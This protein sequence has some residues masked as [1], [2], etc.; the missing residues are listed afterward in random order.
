MNFE[1]VAY[2]TISSLFRRDAVML[3]KWCE[4]FSTNHIAKKCTS[5]DEFYF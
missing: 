3:I 4:I 2:E 1:T 5:K